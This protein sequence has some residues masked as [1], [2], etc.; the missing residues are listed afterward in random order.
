ME[1]NT[2]KRWNFIQRNKMSWWFLKEEEEGDAIQ[3]M[4]Q[5]RSLS[6]AAL[7]RGEG[8]NGFHLPV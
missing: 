7:F 4:A 2:D 5:F 3:D 6:W 8:V 1:V